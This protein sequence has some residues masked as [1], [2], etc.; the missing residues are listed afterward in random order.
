MPIFFTE[1]VTGLQVGPSL[2]LRTGVVLFLALCIVELIVFAQ[3]CV[4]V[5]A[6][7]RALVSGCVRLRCALALIGASTAAAQ[8]YVTK[9]Y[10][11]K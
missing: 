3:V 6:S 2:A 4:C 7:E 8:Q 11:S 9:Q 1:S 10:I 5:R